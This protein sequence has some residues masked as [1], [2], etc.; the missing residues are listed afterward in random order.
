M[1]P[2]LSPTL[3][4]IIARFHG[5]SSGIFRSTF[6]ARSTSTSSTFVYIPL[7]LKHRSE[8]ATDHLE[9]IQKYE[10]ESENMGWGTGN[11][12]ERARQY[13]TCLKT[14]DHTNQ[15][16]ISG[17]NKF[18]WQSS[19]KLGAARVFSK[20]DAQS[21]AFSWLNTCEHKSMGNEIAK[22]EKECRT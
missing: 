7:N 3:S 2:S 8:H 13:T 21:K 19:S 17:P 18:E 11:R 4:A 16:L 15:T 5:F 10:P 20:D 6:P 9:R 22:T 12:G 1:S 14:N